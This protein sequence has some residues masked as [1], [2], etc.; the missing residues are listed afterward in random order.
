MKKIA[1]RLGT[2]VRHFFHKQ[3]MRLRR[4]A[5]ASQLAHS[6]SR[7]EPRRVLTVGADFVQATGILTV[8]I[9]A[10]GNENASLLIDLNSGSFFLDADGDQIFDVD[11]VVPANSEESG[12]LADLRQIIV[13]GTA[14]VGSFLWRGDFTASNALQSVLAQNLSSA[15]IEATANVIGRREFLLGSLHRL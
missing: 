15:T 10:G 5:L 2:A 11:I 7:L 12:S 8:D 1:Q 4:R 13:N 6:F 3:Q 9:T 14:G